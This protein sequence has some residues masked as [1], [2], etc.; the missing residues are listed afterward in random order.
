MIKIN[1]PIINSVAVGANLKIYRKA[2]KLTVNEVMSFLGIERTATLYEWESGKYIPGIDNLYA[3][4]RLYNTTIDSIL[5]SEEDAVHFYKVNI[6]NYRIF[7]LIN[8]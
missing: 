4:S 7:F 8:S 6:R 1:Y 5:C 2:S 3:L